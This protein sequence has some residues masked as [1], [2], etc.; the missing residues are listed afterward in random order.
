MEKE[1]KSKRPVS[2]RNLKLLSHLEQHGIPTIAKGLGITPSRIYNWKY[3]ASPSLENL[4][5]I[6]NMI[7]NIDWNDIMYG[8]EKGELRSTYVNETELERKVR[9]LQ[10]QLEKY[11]KETEEYKLELQE[12]KQEKRKLFELLGKDESEADSLLV[13][14]ELGLQNM[15]ILYLSHGG[16]AL[17]ERLN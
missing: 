9:E 8:N 15:W 7:P 10:E 16:F 4:G 11:K 1:S 13:D 14:N 3:G 2:K 17:N 6:A 12:I 5:E